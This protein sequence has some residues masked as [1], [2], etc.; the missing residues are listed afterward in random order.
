MAKEAEGTAGS[1][2]QTLAHEELIKFFRLCAAKTFSY[3]RKHKIITALAGSLVAAAVVAQAG[4]SWI[5]WQHYEKALRESEDR[6]IDQ[7]FDCKGKADYPLRHTK[8]SLWNWRNPAQIEI[9]LHGEAIRCTHTLE[10]PHMTF[11]FNDG[12]ETWTRKFYRG[13]PPKGYQG[14]DFRPW[15]TQWQ[16]HFNF[17][18]P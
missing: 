7:I 17:A 6:V 3:A 11:Q 8:L 12:N 4:L 15:G 1:A 18:E 14:N 2:S 9:T 13:E 10:I 5:N 16:Q